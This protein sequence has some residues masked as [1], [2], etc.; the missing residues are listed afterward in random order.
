MRVLGRADQEQALSLVLNAPELLQPVA[1]IFLLDLSAFY[2]FLVDRHEQLRVEIPDFKVFPWFVDVETLVEP[3]VVRVLYQSAAVLVWPRR[4]IHGQARKS[5][6]Q[7]ATPINNV[8]PIAGL[9]LPVALL[10]IRA[11][12]FALQYFVVGQ[13]AGLTCAVVTPESIHV[14]EI[15]AIGLFQVKQLCVLPIP[16]S[17]SYLICFSCFEQTSKGR[18][19]LKVS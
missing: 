15:F 6:L 1:G 13:I 17:Q 4:H 2:P 14:W 18:L 10:V 3:I 12:H 9:N 19:L 5:V 11:Y 7:I 8:V 16:E